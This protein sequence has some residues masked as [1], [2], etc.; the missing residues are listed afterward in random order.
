MF[1]QIVVHI[2][3]DD[4][5]HHHVG[6]AID[7]ASQ[8]NAH[9]TGLNT[10]TDIV[11]PTYAEVQIGADII[12]A[13]MK[14]ARKK[15]QA[16]NTTLQKLADKKGIDSRWLIEEGDVVQQ[17]TRHSRYADLLV[18]AQADQ[19]EIFNQRLGIIDQLTLVA[20][21]PVLVVPYIGVKS[22]ITHRLMIAWNG[23][24]ET[25][26]AVKSALPFLQNASEV[27]VVSVRPKSRPANTVDAEIFRSYMLYHQIEFA[28]HDCV[29]TDLSAADTLINW[30][31]DHGIDMLVMGAYGHSRMRELVL[32]GVSEYM[33]R[34]SPI[35]LMVAH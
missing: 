15:A 31:N 16:T 24:R 5:A 29:R 4:G 21:S 3:D 22:P 1:K 6:V 9:L 2:E 28:H 27:H 18:L 19:S 14:A 34:H 10:I 33:L 35:S 11:I 17:V 26:H 32:G 30:A 23:S 12:D 13:S 8:F 7:L 20:G 25:A